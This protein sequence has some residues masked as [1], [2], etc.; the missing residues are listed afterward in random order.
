VNYRIEAIKVLL[1]EECLLVR[2]YSLI[3]LKNRLLDFYE[4][5][6]CFTKVDCLRFPDEK[7]LESGILVPTELSLFKRF[8][9]MY[10]PNPSK[11]KEIDGLNLSKE[12]RDSYKELFLLPGVKSTRASLYYKSGIKSLREM[13]DL[14][15]QEVIDRTKRTIKDYSLN[16]KAPLPKEAKTHIAVATVFFKYRAE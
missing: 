1:N 16:C 4:S 12:E 13:A 11:F 14:T 10:D 7:V 8:L 15:Y 2:Y 3:P 6:G 9:V 5:R